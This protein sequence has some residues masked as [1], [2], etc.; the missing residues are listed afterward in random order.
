[1]HRAFSIT[2]DTYLGD[3]AVFRRSSGIWLDIHAIFF[4]PGLMAYGAG[5]L[6]QTFSLLAMVALLVFMPIF[7]FVAWV[8]V[9][10][11]LL[12]NV[13]W[14]KW[15]GTLLSLVAAMTVAV[16]AHSPG[17]YGITFIGVVVYATMGI[18]LLAEDALL[19]AGYRV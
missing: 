18:L 19:H 11:R 1:M 13:L 5:S 14:L 3:S 17:A 10:N 16:F 7:R 6:L 4:M 8:V 15:S 2:G 12:H 9:S